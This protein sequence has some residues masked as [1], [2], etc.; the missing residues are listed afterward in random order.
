MT[1]VFLFMGCGSDISVS[2]KMVTEENLMLKSQDKETL[3][4]FKEA[5]VDYYV[6]NYEVDSTKEFTNM[7]LAD[8]THDGIEE[9]IVVSREY[10]TYGTN[11]ELSY[12]NVDVFCRNEVGVVTK[13]WNYPIQHAYD[14]FFTKYFL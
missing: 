10:V 14:T 12:G 9:M 2:D 4:V 7:Y 1:I 5:Y 6:S 8:V 11:R 3:D 13:L